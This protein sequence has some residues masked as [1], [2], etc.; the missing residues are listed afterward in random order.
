MNSKLFLNSKPP[1]RR[2][3]QSGASA[4]TIAPIR[5]ER[6]PS[7]SATQMMGSVNPSLRPQ[8]R[9]ETV[10]PSRRILPCK[11]IGTEKEMSQKQLT[12]RDWAREVAKAAARLR[13]TE[14]ES[15]AK[16]AAK[17]QRSAEQSDQKP[18]KPNMGPSPKRSYNAVV[19]SHEETMIHLLCQCPALSR[20]DFLL[21]VSPILITYPIFSQLVS[22]CFRHQ[23][24]L[25]LT[26]VVGKVTTPHGGFHPEPAL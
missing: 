14:A 23:K 22:Y 1:T 5:E 18:N 15:S 21:W 12:L 8:G 6:R 3:S 16:S 4:P 26:E 19:N 9:V 24:P 2:W 10:G 7:A 20:R 11:R 25:V 13:R 17:R